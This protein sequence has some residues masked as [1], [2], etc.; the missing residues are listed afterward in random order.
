MEAG[1]VYKPCGA[2]GGD[3]GILL[4]EDAS[5]ADEFVAAA[6]PDGFKPLDLRIDEQGATVTS[7][8]Q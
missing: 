6:L 5:N 2:G 3:I 7:A 4:A 8:G 1:L